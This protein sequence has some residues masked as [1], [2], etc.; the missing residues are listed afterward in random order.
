MQIK[1]LRQHSV[2]KIEG[3]RQLKIKG[4]PLTFPF[5]LMRNVDQC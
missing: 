4:L 2:M 3:L 5:I 1:G